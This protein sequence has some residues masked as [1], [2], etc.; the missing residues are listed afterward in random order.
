MSIN[1]ANARSVGPTGWPD[2]PWLGDSTRPAGLVLCQ[3]TESDRRS[4]ASICTVCTPGYPFS[5]MIF[6][7]IIRFPW[8]L[9][10][11]HGF[12]SRRQARER[13]FEMFWLQRQVFQ[14]GG[15]KYDNSHLRI[16]G[17]AISTVSFEPL[18]VYL[19]E[20]TGVFFSVK[21]IAF[22]FHAL[23]NTIRQSFVDFFFRGGSK[24]VWPPTGSSDRSK[25]VV[26]F[27]YF[28]PLSLYRPVMLTLV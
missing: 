12:G 28:L 13:G 27:R 16:V 9:G 6:G 7:M 23:G 4:S 18:W 3:R 15:W 24:L 2:S 17:S 25:L 21:E 14:N 19:R 26:W 10:Y 11:L 1:I 22:A 8:S 20:G 5:D